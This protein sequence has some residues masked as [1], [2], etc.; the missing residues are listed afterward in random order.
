MGMEIESACLA[1]PR[2]VQST[3]E[4][5]ERCGVVDDWLI[6]E[7]G[8]FSRHVAESWDEM[9][10][11]ALTAARQALNGDSNVDCIINAS[12]SSRQL[13]PDNSVFVQKGLGLEGVACFSVN[14][15]CASFLV[16]MMVAH[17][18][19]AQGLCSRILIVSAECG[20]MARD[21]NNPLS[22]A[23]LGDGA[24]A[25]V[26]RTCTR[27]NATVPV[28]VRTWSKDA[29]LTEIPAGGLRR[30]PFGHNSRPSDFLFKMNAPAVMMATVRHLTRQLREFEKISPGAVADA[31]WVI[32]HQ[33]S[34]HALTA[35]YRLG[36]PA[37]KTIR[38]VQDYGN[39]VAASMPM[40][41]AHAYQSGKLA[42]G[43][44]LLL[45]GT[46]AGLT[47]GLGSLVW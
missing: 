33:P 21:F 23:L 2:Y 36:L 15:S 42:R 44:R 14:A 24:A 30:H 20:S 1:V 46:A 40:A 22:A 16:A 35:L 11:V 43:D 19:I 10:E 38:I 18:L 37:A 17:G 12:V 5:A 9:E 26:V 27:A 25:V 4:L 39:C 7:S 29:H 31:D 34:G 13:L 3:S 8:I 45:V 41:L 47:I 28:L 6:T 32:P